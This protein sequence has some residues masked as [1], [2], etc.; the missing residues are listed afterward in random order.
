LITPL[1]PA[2][3]QVPSNEKQSFYFCSEAIFDNLPVK[4]LDS[5]STGS[6]INKQINAVVIVS[7]ILNNRLITKTASSLGMIADNLSE[8]TNNQEK[9]KIGLA[10]GYTIYIDGFYYLAGKT[11]DITYNVNLRGNIGKSKIHFANS[12]FALA[13]QN[14]II[15]IKG[16]EFES[17]SSSGGILF[18]WYGTGGV[19][20]KDLAT[21][22]L[23]S[24]SNC[25]F[26]DNA[27]L[28]LHHF[29]VVTNP[30]ITPFGFEDIFIKDNRFENLLKNGPLE[31]NDGRVTNLIFENNIARNFKQEFVSVGITNS[32]LFSLETFRTRNYASFSNNNIVNDSAI[33]VSS[34]KGSYHDAFL[35]EGE[36]AVF[37]NNYIEGIK[38]SVN[39]C[40]GAC[41]INAQNSTISYNTIKNVGGYFKGPKDIDAILYTK[42]GGNGTEYTSTKDVH[43]NKIIF[44]ES[45]FTALGASRANLSTY[46]MEVTSKV[47]IYS[48]HDNDIYY[49]GTLR[50]HNA[51]NAVKSMSIFNNKIYCYSTIGSILYPASTI[52]G[53]ENQMYNNVIAIKNGLVT[54]YRQ[55][56]GRF[57]SKL[58]RIENNYFDFGNPNEYSAQ[59]YTYLGFVN[60]LVLRNNVFKNDL[61]LTNGTI[62]NDSYFQ[63][64][65]EID[66][67]NNSYIGAL[68]ET[69]VLKQLLNSFLDIITK[70]NYNVKFDKIRSVSL[71]N[72]QNIDTKVA[73]VKKKFVITIKSQTQKRHNQLSFPFWIWYD[74]ATSLMNLTYISGADG[75]TKTTM[76]LSTAARGT[77]TFMRPDISSLAQWSDKND[78]NTAGSLVSFRRSGNV[79]FVTI[80]NNNKAFD[81]TSESFD[82]FVQMFTATDILPR[83]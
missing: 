59:Y 23:M 11:S 16:I 3:E 46:L 29:S 18:Y 36:N 17:E 81:K 19:G 75:K 10:S 44:K 34:G 42:G 77:K 71:F 58:I 73:N 8:A 48:F 33:I 72:W 47:G 40:I 66:M 67:V 6:L 4:S 9:L 37:S 56:P 65:I 51:A 31:I 25:Y 32:N 55:V 49:E 57:R 41:Y 35:Y 83:L 24:V 79:F 39:R 2:F 27:R 76:L 69:Y 52:D 43:H 5:A 38:A 63:D 13:G 61:A 12:P 74:S 54:L 64:A 26:H 21:I 7:K 28:L 45:Y 80:E 62:L 14:M 68:P 70:Y 82:V 53:V 60:K 22:K 30:E 20:A 1:F 15:D 78:R 50:F